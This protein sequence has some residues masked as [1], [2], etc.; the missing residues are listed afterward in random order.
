[1]LGVSEEYW[2]NQDWS[3]K[4]LDKRVIW[5]AIC[6][7]FDSGLRIGN[8]TERDGPKGADHCIRAGQLI[9]FVKDPKS[10]EECRLKGGPDMTKFLKRL[11][12]DLSMVSSVDMTYVTSKTSRKVRSLVDNQKT[13]SRR[14]QEESMV[15]DDLLLWFLHSQVQ[16]A[17]EL[18]T[19]YSVTGS[20]KVV[21]RKDVRT[22]IKLAV[23][24][25]GLPAKNFSTK[26]LRSGFGT[27]VTAN[28]MGADEMKARGGW[29]KG[30]GI[31][32]SHYVRHMHSRGALALSVSE[33]G[34]QL[35]GVVI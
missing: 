30:S 4:G 22:A 25:A 3:T 21:I 9:F 34:E 5:L 13:L 16:E 27:H 31:P 2:E 18:L 8:L 1:M 14:T 11:D 32:E 29:V 10:N 28:G 35:H 17:D 26:S 6:L 20:R 33:S 15:L 7:G 19:R 23:S 12:V 24:G